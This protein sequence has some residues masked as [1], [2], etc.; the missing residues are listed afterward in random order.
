MH[1]RDWQRPRTDRSPGTT[2]GPAGPQVGIYRSTT[3]R[4]VAN[5]QFQSYPLAGA[6]PT[7][8]AIPDGV[9]VPDVVYK[10]KSTATR[11]SAGV[12]AFVRRVAV[13]ARQLLRRWTRSRAASDGERGGSAEEDGKQRP[14]CAGFTPGSPALFWT[15]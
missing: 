8:P 1:R 6:I 7:L 4:T 2:R 14:S 11:R 10:V 13:A 5:R 3:R 9:C 12:L 15:R